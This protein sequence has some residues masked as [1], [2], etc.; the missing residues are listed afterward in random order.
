MKWKELWVVLMSA[1]ALVASCGEDSSPENNRIHIIN[2]DNISGIFVTVSVVDGDS[3]GTRELEVADM[4]CTGPNFLIEADVGALITIDAERGGAT[5]SKTC[6]VTSDANTGVG[7][8]LQTFVNVYFED[9]TLTVV[10][11][12]GLTDA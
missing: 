5:A 12:L 2:G 6:R 8:N 7:T 10:C 11:D 3:Y 4:C 1:W 9:T